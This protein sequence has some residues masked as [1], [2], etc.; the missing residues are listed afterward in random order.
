LK[1]SYPS[2]PFGAQG[3]GRNH[4]QTITGGGFG[5]P[6]GSMGWPSRPLVPKGVA[7]ATTS[8]FSLSFFL[9]NLFLKN[10]KFN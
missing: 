2:H 1:K 4:P 8:F 6:L 7:V 10:K 5:H 9:K 3:V